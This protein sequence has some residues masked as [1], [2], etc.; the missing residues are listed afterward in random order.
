M[1]LFYHAP[2][3]RML[4]DVV[5]CIRLHTTIDNA[6]FQKERHADRFL[7]NALRNAAAF[8]QLHRGGAGEPKKIADRCRFSLDELTYTYPTEEL[9]DG[10]MRARAAGK[11]DLG[12]W[13]QALSGGS[14][15]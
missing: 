5:T 7:Q 1:T 13:R 4:Q 10:L 2:D 14:A 3:R 12:G 15:G 9:E 8:P 11:T 6:G